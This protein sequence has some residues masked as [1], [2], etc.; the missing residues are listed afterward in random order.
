MDIDYL[1]LIGECVCACQICFSNQLSR[2]QSDRFTHPA[3]LVLVSPASHLS[4]MRVCHIGRIG[5]HGI[6]RVR[7]YAWSIVQTKNIDLS[8]GM[9]FT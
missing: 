6:V 9:K 4:A 7:V 1:F 2:H 3:Q 8:F 5:R